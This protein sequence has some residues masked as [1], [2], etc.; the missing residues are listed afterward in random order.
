MQC[1]REVSRFLV[2]YVVHALGKW[3]FRP[4]IV[5][6]VDRPFIIMALN[7]DGKSS[8]TTNPR[9]RK[10]SEL[11]DDKDWNPKMDDV[12][13]SSRELNIGAATSRY[14][15]NR[16]S[17]PVTDLKARLSTWGMFVESTDNSPC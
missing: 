10:Y 15:N 12:E 16:Q 4:L 13:V 6:R 14:E 11:D 2:L 9:T 8:G 3:L 5:L 1:Q 17:D 7:F